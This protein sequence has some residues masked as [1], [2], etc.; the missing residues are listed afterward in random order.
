MPSKVL[1]VDDS[2]VI[3]EAA[4]LALEDEGHHVITLDNPLAVAVAVR[5]EQP[6]LV[7]IDVNMPA[8][9]GDVV[10]Q[11]AKQHGVTRR[12]RVVLYSDISLNE[13]AERARRCGATGFIR[14]TGNEAEFVR[15]VNGFLSASAV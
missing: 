10:T 1:I 11:I 8:V 5:K 9:T 6:D 2:A 15:Q 13:L 12:T 7:L 14:K 3:L 4:K